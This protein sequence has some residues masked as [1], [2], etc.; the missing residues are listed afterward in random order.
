MWSASPSVIRA[1]NG[2]TAAT[3]AL[4]QTNQAFAELGQGNLPAVESRLPLVY[5]VLPALVVLVLSVFIRAC[6]AALGPGYYGVGHTA[7][8]WVSEALQAKILPKVDALSA[9]NFMNRIRI[10]TR[11]WMGG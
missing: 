5:G 2:L 6:L 1:R 9:R 11:G 10:R 7:F 4:D 8:A 3:L